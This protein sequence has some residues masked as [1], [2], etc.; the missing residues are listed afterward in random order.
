MATAGQVLAERYE[1]IEQ[2]GRAVI[3]DFGLSRI[4]GLAELPGSEGAPPLATADLTRTGELLGTPAFMAPEQ[5]RGAADVGPAAD[6]YALGLI[7]FEAA[8]GER[9]HP[10][11]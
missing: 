9:P 5:L 11:R 1:L 8:T 6:V 10:Q 4:A 7:L 3:T 2:P